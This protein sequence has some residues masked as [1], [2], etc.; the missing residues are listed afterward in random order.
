M[1]NII[2][3][4]CLI[5][6]FVIFGINKGLAQNNSFSPPQI[7]QDTYYV[8]VFGNFGGESQF[9]NQYPYETNFPEEIQHSFFCSQSLWNSLLPLN[10]NTFIDF[11]DINTICS[12]N[13]NDYDIYALFH[14]TSIS[15]DEV[16]VFVIPVTYYYAEGTNRS[17]MQM[18][19]QNRILRVQ[20]H[21]NMTGSDAYTTALEIR[22]LIR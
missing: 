8:V 3:S 12:S 4:A 13:I 9:F 11:I 1:K 5:L 2:Q 10:F 21:L 19:M 22:L 15:E 16:E 6:L 14:P 18:S 7:Q 17:L 20:E